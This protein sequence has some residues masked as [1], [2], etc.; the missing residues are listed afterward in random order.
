MKL[1]Y[2]VNLEQYE[3]WR[4]SVTFR[5]HTDVQ[6]V[7]FSPYYYENIIILWKLLKQGGRRDLLSLKY[8][9][10]GKYTDSSVAWYNDPVLLENASVYTSLLS[11]FVFPLSLND[12]YSA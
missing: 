7:F 8:L 6:G 12:K 5:S 10:L 2:T 1:S 9:Y 11:N 4:G 3:I